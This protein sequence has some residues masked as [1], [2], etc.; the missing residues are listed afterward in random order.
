MVRLRAFWHGYTQ[1]FGA[2]LVWGLICA[3]GGGAASFDWPPF[4]DPLPF[5]APLWHVP[6]V[7][8]AWV[9]VFTLVFITYR[10]AQRLRARA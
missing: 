7:T 2:G 10:I 5:S 8:L 9:A 6:L 1:V 4:A 3:F